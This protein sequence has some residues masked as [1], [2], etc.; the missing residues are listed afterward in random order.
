MAEDITWAVESIKARAEHDALMSGY[1]RGDQRLAF[2][3]AKFKSV[4]GKALSAFADNLCQAVIETQTSRLRITGFT[5]ED[6]DETVVK[7]AWDVWLK[8]RMDA[9]AAVVHREGKITGDGYVIVWPDREGLPRIYPN[10]SQQ[11]TIERDDEEPERILKAGKLW[12]RKDKYWRLNLYYPDRIEKMITISAGDNAP[13]KAAAYQSFEEQG[14][15]WPLVNPWGVVPVF[16]FSN[17]LTYGTRGR[18]EL[19][20]IVPLQDALNK[21]VTD[22]LVV[23]E[24]AAMPQRYVTGIEIEIDETSGRPKQTPFEPGVDRVWSVAAPDARF[25]EFTPAGLSQFIDVQESFRMEI[26]RVSGIPLHYLM[27][28]G[29]FP[30]GEAM[31]VAESRLVAKIEAAQTEWGNVWENVMALCLAMQ[32]QAGARLSAMWRDAMPAD[33]SA[34]LEQALIKK[35]LGVSMAQIQREIGYSDDQIAQMAAEVQTANALLGEG[36]LTAFDQGRD[37]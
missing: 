4:F 17:N 19:A 12:R 21:S 3:T 32:G 35:Q 7:S 13:D 14:V 15:A 18:S 27:L 22:M 16:N 24:F 28:K 5:S 8:N 9:Q 11:V 25:G 29:D 2:A 31:R 23:M 36:L 33:E 37:A 26:A 30:S 10:R 34:T 20:D 6:G 1:Y